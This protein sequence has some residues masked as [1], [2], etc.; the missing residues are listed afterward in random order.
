MV[1]I[2]FG[3]D[4][5]LGRMVAQATR[6]RSPQSVWDPELLEVFAEADLA[7]V[8][9]ECCI[10]ERGDPWAAPGKPFFFRASPAAVDALRAAGVRAVWLANNHALDF[11][12]AALLDTFHHLEAGGIVWAGAGHDLAEARRGTILTTNGLRLGL[13]GFSDHP[14][15]YEA[16]PEQPGIAWVSPTDLARRSPPAW[17]GEAIGLL[18]ATCD[19]IIVG[20]DWGPNMRPRPLPHHRAVAQR[21]I[22][23]G[24]SIITGHSAHVVQ[25]VGLIDGAPVCYDLGDLLDDYAVDP[26]LRNDLGM[27]ALFHPGERLELVP[28]RLEYTRTGLAKGDDHAWLVDRLQTASQGEGVEFRQERGR[29]VIDLPAI[30]SP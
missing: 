26:E 4:A 30:P 2:A 17:L 11:G 12:T 1:T 21:L 28:L 25:P 22:A 3:G 5:M 10:S 7:I 19:L 29:L 6:G 8:N 16:G 18:R 24:A 23:A 20:P 14:A 27:L 9:L 13:I 15:D